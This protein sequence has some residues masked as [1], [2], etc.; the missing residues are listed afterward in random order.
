[1]QHWHISNW[2][3]KIKETHQGLWSFERKKCLVYQ[4]QSKTIKFRLQR[5]VDAAPSYKCTGITSFVKQNMVQLQIWV[6]WC[7]PLLEFYF[8]FAAVHKGAKLSN[9]THAISFMLFL[10][11]WWVGT[12]LFLGSNRLLPLYDA[13][14]FSQNAILGPFE[15]KNQQNM[16]EVTCSAKHVVNDMFNMMLKDI[17]CP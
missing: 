3:L 13:E 7:V 10:N 5:Y 17:K 14:A 16:W 8:G 11:M 4:R 2:N 9:K 1:M 12:Y 6:L 15:T